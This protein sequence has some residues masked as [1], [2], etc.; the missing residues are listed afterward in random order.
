V[1]DP[2]VQR[3]YEKAKQLGTWDPAAIDFTRDAEQWP[4]LRP[5]EQDLLVRVT[6]IFFA[7][8]EAVIRDLL[9]YAF[10]VTNERRPDDELFVTA[11][12]W[13]E[14]KH[15]DLF[16][17]FLDQVVGDTAVRPEQNPYERRLYDQELQPTMSRLLVDSS[18]VAQAR[19]ITTYCLIIEGLLA[20]TGQRVLREALEARRVLP[21]LSEGLVLVNRD[22]AR[23]VAYGLHVLRRLMEAEASVV[24][25]VNE[26]IAELAPVVSGL[27]DSIIL[28]YGERP[29]GLSY[30]LEEPLERLL[31]QLARLQPAT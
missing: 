30:A 26:R 22:E 1:R 11:W 20:D 4:Q 7:G 31:N 23:H 27:A 14:G 12:L 8:E 29:F 21:G 10:V 28:R 15:A 16:R 6:S 24:R 3:L 18:A 5:D 19:A 2:A 17:R 13:E 25:V 9:P